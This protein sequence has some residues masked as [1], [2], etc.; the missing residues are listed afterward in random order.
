MISHTYSDNENKDIYMNDFVG[1]KNTKGKIQDVK[2]WGKDTK[3][4][5]M[6]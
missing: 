2:R 5:Y 1:V 3:F 4:V 6:R